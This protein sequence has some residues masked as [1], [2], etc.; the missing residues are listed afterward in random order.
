MCSA[1]RLLFLSTTA[2][3]R[4]ET[5]REK[6]ERKLL[7]VKRISTIP[8]TR[9]GS[10]LP[11]GDEHRLWIN[12]CGRIHT[13][14]LSVLLWTLLVFFPHGLLLY[15]NFPILLFALNWH[16]IQISKGVSL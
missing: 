13:R 12:P 9:L 3:K 2:K 11:D 5:S 15:Y 6:K 1:S 16:K 7:P 4:D 10:P 8:S 14:S